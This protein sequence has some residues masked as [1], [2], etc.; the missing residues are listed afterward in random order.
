MILLL[1]ML[2]IYS[3]GMLIANMYNKVLTL[4]GH[5]I[6]IT[7]ILVGLLIEALV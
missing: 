2:I 6:A 5:L 4:Q 1:C 3:V 7:L